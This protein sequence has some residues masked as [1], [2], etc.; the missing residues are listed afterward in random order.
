M[1][2]QLTSSH[3]FSNGV[4]HA[5]VSQALLLAV[6]SPTGNGRIYNV[7]D[8]EP[9]VAGELLHFFGQPIP[10]DATQRPLENSWAGLVDTARIKAEL[11]FCPLYP[12]F[13]A[14]RDAR[15]L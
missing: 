5:D 1:V 15:V 14:A 11:G 7:A 2:P 3:T 10:A 8:D 6:D 12:S 9:V 13:N 4:H